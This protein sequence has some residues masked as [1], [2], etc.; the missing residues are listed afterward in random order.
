M[1]NIG[2]LAVELIDFL[3]HFEHF[4]FCVRSTERCE[5]DTSEEE[6]LYFHGVV[7]WHFFLDNL[8][9]GSLNFGVVEVGVIQ[10]KSLFVFALVFILNLLAF[11]LWQDSLCICHNL[12]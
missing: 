7:L 4:L 6:F 11:V 1:G 3:N 12:Y 5:F 8:L 10:F 2:V 9:Y